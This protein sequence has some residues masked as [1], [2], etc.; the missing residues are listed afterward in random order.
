MS[1]G[2]VVVFF[3]HTVNVLSSLKGSVIVPFFIPVSENMT[4]EYLEMNDF[5][6]FQRK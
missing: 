6:G 2:Y 4:I 1:L 5:T 3:F